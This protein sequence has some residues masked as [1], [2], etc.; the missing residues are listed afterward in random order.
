MASTVD[1]VLLGLVHDQSRSA[2]DIQKHIEYR[3]LSYWVK[4]STPSIYKRMIVLEE[5]GYLK[6]KIIKNGKN[7]EKAIYKITQKGLEYFDIMMEE[8]SKKSFQV[9]FDFNAVIVG[10]NKVSKGEALQYVENIQ[11]NI[12]ESLSFITIT[13]QQKKNIPLVGRTIMKQQIMVLDSLQKWCIEFKQEIENE[14]S[15]EKMQ[16]LGGE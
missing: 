13:R 1:L 11:K 14:E 9:L 15:L 16:E 4:I 3:N 2:Y 7:P 10:L 12:E 8:F 6:K 5:S